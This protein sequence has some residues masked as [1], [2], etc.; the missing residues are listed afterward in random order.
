[1][2]ELRLL[3]TTVA[4]AK[5]YCDA[6]QADMLAARE[7]SM[8]SMRMDSGEATPEDR[9]R[10]LHQWQGVNAKFIA[11]RNVLDTALGK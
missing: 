5:S 11:A 6:R 1:M 10:A 2:A 3:R 7:F 8:T 9:E 4:A